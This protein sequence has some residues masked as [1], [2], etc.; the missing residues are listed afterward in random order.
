[1]REPIYVITGKPT[2]SG[3]FL[4]YDDGRLYTLTIEQIKKAVHAGRGLEKW[5]KR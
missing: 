1:M 4:V 5:S 2:A 3:R